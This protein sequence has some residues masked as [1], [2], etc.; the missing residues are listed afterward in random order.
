MALLMTAI[1]LGLDSSAGCAIDADCAHRHDLRVHRVA[2]TSAA[3][4]P[5]CANPPHSTRRCMSVL[6]NGQVQ[7][8]IAVV[9]P[10][11]GYT[12][13]GPEDSSMAPLI[14]Q[15]ASAGAEI[16]VFPEN[17]PPGDDCGLPTASATCLTWPRVDETKDLCNSSSPHDDIISATA[18]LAKQFKVYVSFNTGDAQDCLRDN[19]GDPIRALCPAAGYLAFNTQVVLSPGGHL[20]AKHYKHYLFDDKKTQPTAK[21]LDPETFGSQSWFDAALPQGGVVRFGLAVCNDINHANLISNYKTLG[22]ADLIVAD[23][24]APSI[25]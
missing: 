21:M 14:N 12:V 1:A 5:R 10:P 2:G 20:V 8:S 4:V 16:V 3:A 9:Q 22:I 24:C 7:Y 11:I 17:G 19:S 23:N 6:Q 15:S 25:P 18:C 13:Y